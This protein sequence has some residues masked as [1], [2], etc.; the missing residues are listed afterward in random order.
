M[1]KKVLIIVE[2]FGS[3]VFNFLVDLV[4]G[5]DKEFDVVI[6]YGL[7]EETLSN[8]KDYFGKYLVINR[9]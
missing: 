9:K 8:F 6:A 2:S 3:G 1:K 7:R 5:I 4:N